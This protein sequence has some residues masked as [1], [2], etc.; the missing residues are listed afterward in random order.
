MSRLCLFLRPTP[1][2]WS[3]LAYWESLS[4][5]EEDRKGLYP[6]WAVGRGA[7]DQRCTG[8]DKITRN[9]SY[10][11]QASYPKK[12]CSQ[13]ANGSKGTGFDAQIPSETGAPDQNLFIHWAVKLVP[14]IQRCRLSDAQI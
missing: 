8:F 12:G 5:Q 2:P 3:D 4:K 13:G 11:D 14:L 7:I 6:T 10:C 1:L 9:W